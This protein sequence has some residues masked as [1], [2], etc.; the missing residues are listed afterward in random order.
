MGKF[1]KWNPDMK[2]LLYNQ[3]TCSITQHQ[4]ILNMQ[5]LS[6]MYSVPGT[7]LMDLAIF[8]NYIALCYYEL[9]SH[10]Q[11]CNNIQMELEV[12]YREI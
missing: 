12:L 2:W 3:D 9:D 11:D 8:N 5:Q 4:P 10:V 6:S 7:E 1:V